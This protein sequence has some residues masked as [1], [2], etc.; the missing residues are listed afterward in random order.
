M[1]K[2]L[3][4]QTKAIMN[5]FNA[6]PVGIDMETRLKLVEVDASQYE[7]W[8]NKNTEGEGCF[9]NR[10]VALC[11]EHSMVEKPFWIVFFHGA[12][13]RSKEELFVSAY[14]E[15]PDMTDAIYKCDGVEADEAD[16][17]D[18]V[19]TILD[20]ADK[21]DRH[22]F[23]EDNSELDSPLADDNPRIICDL[24]DILV[25]ILNIEIEI[26]TP[27][28]DVSLSTVEKLE[29]ALEKA[30]E[31]YREN[32][33]KKLLCEML[34]NENCPDM[35]KD[36]VKKHSLDTVGFEKI[37]ESEDYMP[38]YG[39]YIVFKNNESTEFG[40][41]FECTETYA[42]NYSSFDGTEFKHD[43]HFVE[44]MKEYELLKTEDK[45]NDKDTKQALKTWE[46]VL[47]FSAI[48]YERKLFA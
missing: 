38:D 43:I 20:I 4:N 39:K 30:K 18:G 2:E 41:M 35:L 33:G 25:S 48:G 13:Y 45:W 23:S 32:E 24:A 42:E 1:T 36:F 29:T 28:K 46:Y 17:E 16:K 12:Q 6:F 21:F 40:F 31:A 44:T 47:S 7:Y 27:L 34:D 37:I 5:E 15:K 11:F 14:W 22:W 9:I 10:A 26:S 3:L 8:S 19:E